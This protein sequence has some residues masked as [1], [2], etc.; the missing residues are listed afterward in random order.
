LC[1]RTFT[2]LRVILNPQ[3]D[4]VA[5][6]LVGFINDALCD[7]FV[8]S[9]RLARIVKLFVPSFRNFMPSLRPTCGAFELA[10]GHGLRNCSGG[11]CGGKPNF[12][13]VDLS[14]ENLRSLVT[15]P[16]IMRG[17]GMREL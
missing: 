6:A 10:R 1:L 11:G 8:N 2:C 14:T 3:L 7:H 5:L 4:G 15:P 16:R 12:D 9:F 13:A 17:Y